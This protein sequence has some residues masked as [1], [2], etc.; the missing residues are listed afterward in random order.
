MTATRIT[1]ETTECSRCW[2]SGEYGPK[3]VEGGRCFK[4]KGT[5]I[6]LSRAGKA[7]RDRFED[8]LN[9]MLT[10]YSEVKVGDRI[11]INI[12]IMSLKMA[13]RTVT[14]THADPL[15]EG[16]WR[17]ETKSQSIGTFM[18]DNLKVRVWDE[19]KW[20]AA[21]QA[22]AHLKGA[23]TTANDDDVQHASNTQEDAQKDAQASKK[24]SHAMCTHDATPK[25]RA[26]CRKARKA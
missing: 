18:K 10:P 2:G 3:Q 5:G 15:N 25:A 4:C 11:W 9:A 14:D 7:A 12:S 22:V 1:F 6:Q 24:G 8:K 21:V 17:V 23:T 20:E 19:A 16:I 13:W 26:A